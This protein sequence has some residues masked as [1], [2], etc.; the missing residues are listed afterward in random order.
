MRSI[1]VF[2]CLAR[3][4]AFVAA[5]VLGA[6]LFVFSGLYPVGADDRHNVLTNWILETARER[7]ISRA[8]VG[9]DVPGDLASPERLLTGGA[10]YSEM[11]AGCHLQPGLLSTDLSDGLYP[12]PANLT[13]P[14]NGHQDLEDQR[15]RR[16]WII[17]HGIK[18]SGMPAWGSG[19]DDERIWN[20]VAFLDRLPELTSQQYQILTTRTTHGTSVVPRS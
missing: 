1:S 8:S 16:F 3:V 10:D 17:K 11:C 15:R 14:T 4:V 7:S 6:V 12:V 9:I 19:H 20:M 2:Q 13:R 5:L 18:A